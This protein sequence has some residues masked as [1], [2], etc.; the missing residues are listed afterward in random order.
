LLEAQRIEYLPVDL[1]EDTSG[2]SSRYYTQLLM[3][4]RLQRAELEVE[5]YREAIVKDGLPLLPGMRKFIMNC[6]TSNKK[7]DEDADEG[8]K[9][10]GD[11]SD[12]PKSS[13]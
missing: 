2:D 4:Q 5:L 9:E 6:K 10:D 12:G 11:E 8:V 13:G 7:M 1:I 3:A